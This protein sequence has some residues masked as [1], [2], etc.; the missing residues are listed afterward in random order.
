MNAPFFSRAPQAPALPPRPLGF[1]LYFVRNR[2]PWYVSML[3]LE[4]CHALCGILLPYA[5]ARIVGIVTGMG[6]AF[7]GWPQALSLPLLFFVALGAGEVLFSRAA[8]TLQFYFMPMQ[9]QSVTRALYAYLQQ[10]SHRYLSDNFA[11]ALAHRIAETAMGVNQIMTAIIFDFWPVALVFS[12]SV[13]LLLHADLHLAL[14]VL[15]WVV[16]FVGISWWLATRC[17]PYAIQSAA[18]RSTTTGKLVDS[19]TNLFSARLFARLDFERANLD[20]Q[21]ACELKAVRRAMWYSERVRWFQ[22]IA[23]AVLKIGILYYALVLWSRGKIGVGEFVLATGLALHIINEARN[24]SRRFLEFFEFIGNVY[25]GVHT[26]I[27]PHELIDR[28]G[29]QP[30][31]LQRG[32]IEFVRV[33]FGYAP[34]LP[35]F[36]GLSLHIPAGQRVGLVGFSGSGKSSFVNL[37]LRLY[38]LQD[39]RIAIDGH[40]IRDLPQENLHA[41]IGLIPQD[42]SLFHR[43]LMENIRYGRIEASD[44]E[45]IEA[46]K[47]AHAH[48]FITQ[49]PEG[50]AAM[51]GERG[52]KLS[53]GQRQR[54]AIARVILKNAPVLILDEATASL[55]SLTEKAIQETMDEVMH[56]KTVIVIA[57][58]L[59]TIAHLD[60]ILVFDHGRIIEDGRHAELLARGGTYHRLWSGQAGGFLSGDDAP[61]RSAAEELDFQEELKPEWDETGLVAGVVA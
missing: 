19:V 28:P 46:A 14:F 15:A 4:G 35:I 20:E 40:D 58:R 8:G 38:E 10:H 13:G 55:D 18:A 43:T 57:H 49:M 25:N 42:P 60:R 1:T 41:Q 50:Y 44:E 2:L 24:L 5:I 16:A 32:D 59:S 29:A 30:A 36:D 7:A 47:R 3:L 17:R 51:V 27:Q 54:I 21:L 22:F 48:E 11:G 9:R 6:S 53:G 12:V 45:V 33:R 39:G 61:A 31:R 56:G 23:A 52:V 34:Q 26:L 37:L